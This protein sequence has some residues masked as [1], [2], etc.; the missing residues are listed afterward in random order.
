MKTS[1]FWAATN[2]TPP[3]DS[4]YWE[5]TTTSGGLMPPT[6]AEDSPPWELTVGAQAQKQT[7]GGGKRGGQ[8]TPL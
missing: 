7:H 1:R 6:T 5:L 3:G 2:V 4:P 8:G